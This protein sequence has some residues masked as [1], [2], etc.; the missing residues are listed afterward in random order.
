MIYRFKCPVCG[1]TEEIQMRI[2]KYRPSGHICKCGAELIRDITDFGM[3]YQT[4]CDGFYA[5]HQSD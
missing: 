5:D 3:N 4:K 1:Q 2:S